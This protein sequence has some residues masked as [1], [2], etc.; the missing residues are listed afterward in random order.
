MSCSAGWP[1]PIPPAPPLSAIS[2]KPPWSPSTVTMPSVL[3]QLFDRGVRHVVGE[4][5]LTLLQRRDHR[6]GVGEH[7]ED[8]AVDA[9]VA[10]VPVRVA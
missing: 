2:V 10:P 5:D 8:D 7:A 6:V 1:S 9:V 4:V 3:E